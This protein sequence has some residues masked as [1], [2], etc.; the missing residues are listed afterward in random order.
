MAGI[1]DNIGLPVSGINLTYDSSL[2]IGTGDAEILVSLKARCR[3]LRHADRPARYGPP[4]QAFPGVSFAFLPADMVS[5]ILNLGLPAPI[6]IQ[7]VGKDLQGNRR[8]QCA[9]HWP[10]RGRRRDRGSSFGS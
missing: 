9:G 5:Q 4:Q 10:S 1:V 7:I 2:P 3:A 8:R 6:D